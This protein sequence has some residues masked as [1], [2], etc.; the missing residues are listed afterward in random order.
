MDE[1]MFSR[2]NLLF[3]TINTYIVKDYVDLIMLYFHSFFLSLLKLLE[4]LSQ[5]HFYTVEAVNKTNIN[6]IFYFKI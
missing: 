1:W 3:W 2:F 5:L 4:K 6:I